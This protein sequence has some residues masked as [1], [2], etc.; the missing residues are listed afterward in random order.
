MKKVIVFGSLN[1]DMTI[2]C[3]Q[4]PQAGQTVEGR[5]FFT[6]PGGKGGNQAAAAAKM[7]APTYMI[8]R[9][10]EDLFGEQI[11]QTLLGYGVDCRYVDK[12]AHS[13]TGVA[14]ITRSGG[15]NRIVLSKGSNHEITGREVEAALDS[16]G[17]PLDIFVTQYECS[18]RAVTDSLAAAKRRGLFTIFNPAPAKAIPP[19]S[20]PNIDLIVV[21]QTEC[22]FLT[23]LYPTDRDSCQAALGRFKALGA[24]GAILTLGAAGSVCRMGGELIQVE[25]FSVPNVDTTAAGDSYIGALASSLV[26]GENLEQGM[27]L[28]TKTAALTITRQGAQQSIPTIGEVEAYFREEDGMKERI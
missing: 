24:G 14:I 7:G 17:E 6:N 16:L 23:G 11:V 27:R 28:A 20:Y 4:M 2:E 25:S 5:G 26:R 12:S 8:A 10:G 9:V 19:E 21:N 22:E 1:M 13:S 18:V 15:D 3:D